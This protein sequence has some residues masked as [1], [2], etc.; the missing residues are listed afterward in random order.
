MQKSSQHTLETAEGT[1]ILILESVAALKTQ[2]REPRDRRFVLCEEDDAGAVLGRK[3]CRA[4]FSM[5]ARYFWSV[6]FME[7]NV[8]RPKSMRMLALRKYPEKE[9]K[10]LQLC[11]QEARTSRDC[12]R[13]LNQS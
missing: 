10:V 8:V 12:Q 4:G 6:S 9:R 13:L 7:G 2:E 3:G 11:E 1:L 5:R